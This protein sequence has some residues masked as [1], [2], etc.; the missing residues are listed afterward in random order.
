MDDHGIDADLLQQ[1][2]VARKGE[3][4]FGVAHR[5]AAVFD[6]ESA[7]S[8]SLQIGQSLG[9]RFRF[10]GH[11]RVA[12]SDHAPFSCASKWRPNATNPV[13]IKGIT[14]SDSATFATICPAISP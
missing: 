5:M 1:H 8:V 9:Q 6:H 12:C 11:N 13:I 14:T 10:I 2:H 7:A 4:G 3:R